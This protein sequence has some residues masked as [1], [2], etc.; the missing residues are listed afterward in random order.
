MRPNSSGQG[1]RVSRNRGTIGR[2]TITCSLA[3]GVSSL[4]FGGGGA[5]GA[6]AGRGGGGGAW[7]RSR[8]TSPVVAST[9]QGPL[10]A[11]ITPERGG[12]AAGEGDANTFVAP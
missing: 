3:V 7:I 9:Y 8:P 10:S 6:T 1:K 12:R 4:R 2:S 5:T 11:T